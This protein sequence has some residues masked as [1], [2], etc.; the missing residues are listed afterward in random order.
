MQIAGRLFGQFTLHDALDD[1]E[2]EEEE[3]IREECG[4]R[5]IQM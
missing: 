5:F 1:E 3:D 2:E 4:V